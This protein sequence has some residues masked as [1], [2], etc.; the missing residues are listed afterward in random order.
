MSFFKAD[1]WGSILAIFLVMF[2]L[3]CFQYFRAVDFKKLDS[4]GIK[5]RSGKLLFGV[6]LGSDNFNSS[7]MLVISQL[8][9][10]WPIWDSCSI[11]SYTYFF[12]SLFVHHNVSYRITSNGVY[13]L[14]P[15]FYISIWQRIFILSFFVSF[16]EQ[17]NPLDEF[18]LL[19]LLIWFR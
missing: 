4:F 18:L 2:L 19:R 12:L 8:V 1:W 13:P 17:V 16:I 15:F 10:L 7:V 5:S 9:C 3:F 14:K 6:V 11:Y